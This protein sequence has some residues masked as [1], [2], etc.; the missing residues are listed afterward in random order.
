MLSIM[1]LPW[2]IRDSNL[3]RVYVLNS[4]FFKPLLFNLAASNFKDS[5]SGL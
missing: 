4:Y 2:S 1:I 3:Y 5:E